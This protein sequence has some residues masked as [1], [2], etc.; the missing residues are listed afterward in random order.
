MSLHER[1]TFHLAIATDGAKKGGTKDMGGNAK[2]VGNH[3]RG[4]AGTGVGGDTQKQTGGGVGTA[5]KKAIS[6]AGPNG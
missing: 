6:F 5:E 1:H 4:V 3:I 2:A